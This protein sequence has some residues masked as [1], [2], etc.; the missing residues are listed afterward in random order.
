MYRSRLL[1]FGVILSIFLSII[2]V[3]AQFQYIYTSFGPKYI[4]KEDYD[5]HLSRISGIAAAP[6]RY[7]VL[8][9]YVL[10]KVMKLFPAQD[11]QERARIYEK[12]AFGF[13]IGQNIIIFLLA[14]FYFRSLKL[15]FQ[16]SFIGMIL[17]AYGMCFAFVQSDLSYYIYTQI[18]FFLLAAT[19]I[20]FQKYNWLIPLT[21]IAAF[22][23]EEAIFIPLMLLGC[24]IIH[25]N[26]KIFDKRTVLLQASQ[27]IF[28][29]GSYFLIYFGLRYVLGS[30]G[31]SISRY[32]MVF[33]GL[34]LFRLNFLNPDT[35][36]GLSLMYSGLPFIILYFRKWPAIL[37]SYLICLVLPWFMLEFA[38]GSS[39]ETR[40]FLVPLFIVFVPATIFM[41]SN[42]NPE[43]QKN[44]V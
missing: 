39:D 36:I 5:R 40:L 31:Y 25:F 1:L 37:K 20:N 21:I 10:G 30:A 2:T 41:L 38:F 3:G 16:F 13:R 24:Q 23:R 44:K 22:N 4:I 7:R 18:A 42:L 33:P 28:C 12:V 8:T 19:L 9:D 17:C 43:M 11:N 15:S 6:L 29:F 32:G 26:F 34:E 27:L 14:L 35:W